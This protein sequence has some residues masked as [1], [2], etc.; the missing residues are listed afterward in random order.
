MSGTEQKLAPP[1]LTLKELLVLA[2]QNVKHYLSIFLKS[3]KGEQLEIAFYGET[4]I[5]IVTYSK[6][7]QTRSQ[8]RSVD[9]RGGWQDYIC[10][11]YKLDPD[12]R[13]W[14]VAPETYEHINKLFSELHTIDKN[15]APWGCEVMREEIHE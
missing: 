2:D 9:P 11:M 4:W 8:G 7:T 6:K 3:N 12:S 1:M 13:N 10:K 5:K 14:Y 15:L